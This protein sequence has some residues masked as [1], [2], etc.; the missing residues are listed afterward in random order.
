MFWETPK[1]DPRT[2]DRFAKVMTLSVRG[3]RNALTRICGDSAEFYFSECANNVDPETLSCVGEKVVGSAEISVEVWQ[4][5][6]AKKR[7]KPY[8][9]KG[10]N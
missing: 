4:L 8:K 10:V 6:M 1:P 9:L 7:K 2:I 3:D 5:K